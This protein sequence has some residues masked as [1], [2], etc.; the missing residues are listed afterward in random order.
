MSINDPRYSSDSD[1]VYHPLGL[2]LGSVRSL[3]SL[4]IC[5]F[6]WLILLWPTENFMRPLLG[7]FFLLTLVLLAFGSSP[8]KGEEVRST[9]PWFIRFLFVGGSIAVVAFLM[10]SD[11]ERL[12]I[13]L[14]PD[15]AELQAWWA[16]YLGITFS[17]FALGVFLRYVLG[18]TNAIFMTFRAWLAVLGL[19]TLA[20]EVGLVV[21]MLSSENKPYEFAQYWEAVSLAIVSTYFGTRA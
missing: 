9:L 11:P 20:L 7:H 16:V 15:P 17:G 6:F 4:F 1:Q 12:R 8:N 14:T 5:V 3:M 13:R 18:Q 19:I 10:Y 21:I 2:A